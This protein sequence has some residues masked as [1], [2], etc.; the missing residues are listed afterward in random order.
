[1]PRRRTYRRSQRRPSWINSSGDNR[2]SGCQAIRDHQMSAP[3]IRICNATS[4]LPRGGLSFC[5]WGSSE[6]TGF[7]LGSAIDERVTP[8][9]PIAYVQ[10]T[11]PFGEPL[12][13]FQPCIKEMCA[14]RKCRYRQVQGRCN[15]A[16][17]GIARPRLQHAAEL[18]A[19]VRGVSGFAQRSPILGDGDW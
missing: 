13:V 19:Q 6:D 18:C 15:R 9:T 2:G 11:S 7:R 14:G 17:V 5:V 10:V 3:A 16:V 1:M 4:E 12:L 8:T